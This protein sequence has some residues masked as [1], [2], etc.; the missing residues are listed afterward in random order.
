MPSVHKVTIGDNSEKKLSNFND[1]L[2][3]IDWSFSAESSDP[4]SSHNSF[5]AYDK[6]NDKEKTLKQQ[7]MRIE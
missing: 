6:C 1:Q 2:K 3:P 4:N 5:H 7:S